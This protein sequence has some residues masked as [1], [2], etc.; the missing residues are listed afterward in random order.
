MKRIKL[1]PKLV[2]LFLFI[3]LVPLG[4]TGYLNLLKSDKMVDLETKNKLEAVRQIKKNQISQFFEERLADVSVLAANPFTRQALIDMNEAYKT[5]GGE[6]GGQLVGTG[7]FNFTA[8]EE[9]REIH[10]KYFDFFK[11]YVSEY[12]YY[13]F[14]LQSADDGVISFTVF[15]E[16]DFGKTTKNMS[17]S[18]GKTWRK[19]TEGHVTVS[20]ISPYAPSNDAPAM[21]V[22]APVKE[23][24][25]ILGVISLQISTDAINKIMQ[26]RS[27]LGES[28][29]T[30][31]VGQDK[32]MRTDSRFSKE[33]TLLKKEVN[34]ATV[35]KALKGENG[36]EM[37]ADYR[38][39]DVWSCYDQ[40]DIGGVKWAVLA[41]IDDEEAMLHVVEMRNYVILFC[42]V[43][44]IGIALFAFFFSRT[45]SRPIN[46]ISRVA[47]SFAK[48]EDIDKTI[49]IA[50]NDEIGQLADSFRSMQESLQNLSGGLN[51]LVAATVEGRLQVRADTDPFNGE[52]KNIVAGVNNMLGSLVGYID[53]VPAPALI[54]DRDFNIQ[55][56]NRS[57]TEI[58]GVSKDQVLGSKCYNHFK[59]KDCRNANCA[60]V[61]AMQ[62]GTNVTSETQANPNDKKLDIS[63]TGVPVRGSDGQIIGAFEIVT[64]LTDIKQAGRLVEKQSNYQ[65]GEVKKLINLMTKVAS[66]DLQVEFSINRAD[67]DTRQTAENFKQ[68]SMGFNAMISN[69]RQFVQDVQSASEQVAA[70]ASQVTQTAQSIAQGGEEQAASVEQISSSMEEMSSTVKENANNALQTTAIAGKSSGDAQ[71]G[72]EAVIKTVAAMQNI[73]ERISIIEEIARQT[74]MLALNAAIEAARAGEHG[75]GFAVVAA[76]VRKLAERSQISAQEILT[77][78]ESSVGIAD[79][80]GKLIEKIVPGIKKTS[81]LVGEISASSTEQASGIDQVATAISQLD[82]VVQQNSAASEELASTSEE[83]SSQ[84][85]MLRQTAGF[86]KIGAV[87]NTAHPVHMSKNAGASQKQGALRRTSGITLDTS[88]NEEEDVTD[89][90]FMLA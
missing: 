15:K 88:S 71:E 82:R 57:A 31:L 65:T 66:G 33:S 54:I 40:V 14:F 69:I 30:Y 12:G 10:D 32:L 78:S 68:I 18:F 43:F 75:K 79:M 45:I 36:C 61:R 16:P 48:G 41:E 63:Y 60:I 85:H 11:Y 6:A 55:Y 29:E 5:I 46:A 44:G 72:G 81:D 34:T 23:G 67:E 8:P 21:F 42:I 13:D 7:N 35:E 86:F 37:T 76:E 58:F 51:E 24:E 64:D 74:N 2:V 39:T 84:A 27:G 77:L 20:D 56:A 28:G 17:E 52:W 38:G 25:K 19:A 73:A 70:G 1:G 83:L 90:D 62:T 53:S 80:A 22:S 47:E 87:S 89:D 59:T 4:V 26:E 49:D 3:G 50:R 9:Y